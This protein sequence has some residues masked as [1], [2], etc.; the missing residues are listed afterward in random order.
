[1]CDA[2]D[3]DPNAERVYKLHKKD[4]I[5]GRGF[6]IQNH[7][8]NERMRDIIAKYKPKYHSLNREGKRILIEAVHAEVIEGGAKFLKKLDGEKVW[9]VVALPIALNKIRQ[10]VKRRKNTA[11]PFDHENWNKPSTLGGHAGL[12]GRALPGMSSTLAGM[13]GPGAIPGMPLAAAAAGLPS[14]VAASGMY[15]PPAIGA[16]ETSLAAL[17]VQRMA[18]LHR[19]N[20]IT[21]MA[22][23]RQR[24]IE[25]HQNL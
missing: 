6:G 9:V 21:G 19:Y 12:E 25:H 17:E 14:L 7:P 10:S 13:P 8:G 5:L 3:I 20:V 1:M 22:A 2:A 15:A 23:A 18:A 24:D 4:I 11:R 16:E